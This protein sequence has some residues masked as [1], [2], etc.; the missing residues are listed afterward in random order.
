[1]ALGVLRFAGRF[2]GRRHLCLG[3]CVG[4]RLGRGRGG[5]RLLGAV[6]GR[7]LRLHVMDLGRMRIGHRV[8][9][10]KAGERAR[11]SVRFIGFRLGFGSRGFGV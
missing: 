5:V 3:G 9:L 7:E 8:G 6:L 1:M 2:R 4:R 11:G 10:G